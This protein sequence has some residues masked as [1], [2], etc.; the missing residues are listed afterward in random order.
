[1]L[2]MSRDSRGRQETG[3]A[4]PGGGLTD[5]TAAFFGAVHEVVSGAAVHM[6]VDEARGE[7][8]ASEI[9]DRAPR[10]GLRFIADN[11]DAFAGDADLAVGHR[12]VGEHDGAVREKDWRHAV[13][14]CRACRECGLSQMRGRTTVQ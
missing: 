9:D 2:R 11:I 12:A 7:V 10:R 5:Y 8:A 13:F 1:M 14:I 3:G 4:V 6:N